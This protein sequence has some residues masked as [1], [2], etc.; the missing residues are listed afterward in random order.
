MIIF[1]FYYSILLDLNSAEV[2]HIDFGIAFESGLCL[3]TPETVPFRLTREIIAGMGVPGYEGLFR[4]SAEI[5]MRVLRENQAMIMAIL[6]VLLHDPLYSWQLTNEKIK[7][8]QSDSPLSF[9][10]T[11]DLPEISTAST[12]ATAHAMEERNVTA[13]RA[14]DRVLIKLNGTIGNDSSQLSVSGIVEYLIQQ[15]TSESN[16]SKLFYGFQAYW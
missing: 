14:L 12:V 3:P 10:P 6:E 16:L 15:A 1:L 8:T 13:Q 7:K 2:V 4:K 5:T 11:D 9:S